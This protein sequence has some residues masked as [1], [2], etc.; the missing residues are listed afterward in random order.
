MAVGVCHSSSFF[1]LYCLSF[2]FPAPSGFPPGRFMVHLP[3]YFSDCFPPY[4][5]AARPTSGNVSPWYLKT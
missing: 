2:F 5:A 3:Y 4:P 1:I